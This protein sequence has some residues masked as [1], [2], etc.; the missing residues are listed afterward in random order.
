MNPLNRT[1]T[2]FAT[3]L[4]AIL[5]SAVFTGAVALAQAP[6]AV[7]P[8]ELDKI[9]SRIA[10]YPDPLL[11]QILGAATYPE[12]IPDAAQWADQHHYLAGDA[13]A[14]AIADDH[15]PWDP[16]VQALLPFP[17][18]LETMAGDM[19]WTDQLSNAV[20]AQRA[21]VM[22][23]VQRMR[24]KAR[25][26]GYLRSSGQIVVGTGPYITI[27]PVNPEFICVPYYDPLIV[28][29]A[30]R[31]GVSLGGS[32]IFGYGITIGAAFRPWGWGAIRFDWGAHSWFIGNTIWNRTWADRAGYKGPYGAQRFETG[33]RVEGHEL[34]QRSQHEREAGRAGHTRVEEHRGR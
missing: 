5:A 16:S 25:D 27:L 11:A 22:D 30:M 4:A 33:K 14:K 24:K 29:A 34:I 28:F 6:A 20:L 21:E 10:L 2:S 9:V 18:V 3:R 7:S 13:L 19:A 8:G 1:R 26:F 23:A 17:S 32:I 15:L 31:R 12:D